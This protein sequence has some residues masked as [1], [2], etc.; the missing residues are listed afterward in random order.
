MLYDGVFTSD[1]DY[2]SIYTVFGEGFSETTRNSTD[3]IISHQFML[4]VQAFLTLKEFS[5]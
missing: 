4:P 3:L 2:I 5:A 1:A